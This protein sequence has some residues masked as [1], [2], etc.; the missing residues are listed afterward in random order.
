MFGFLSKSKLWR[1][2][3]FGRCGGVVGVGGR[4]WGSGAVLWG[5]VRGCGM[6]LGGSFLKGLGTF[7]EGF[8]MGLWF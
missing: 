8:V 2:V 6:F 5:R 3:W 7:F 1:R 4:F